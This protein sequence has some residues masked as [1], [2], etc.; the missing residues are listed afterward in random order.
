[1]RLQVLLKTTT[2]AARKPRSYQK[3]H[4]KYPSWGNCQQGVRQHIAFV[5]SHYQM[6]R[7]PWLQPRSLSWCASCDA[8]EFERATPMRSSTLPRVS[9]SLCEP[10]S[11]ATWQLELSSKRPRSVNRSLVVHQTRLA[12]HLKGSQHVLHSLVCTSKRRNGVRLSVSRLR[13][14]SLSPIR[15]TRGLRK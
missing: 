3:R 1:M 5:M 9:L 8:S 14:V 6:K 13:C 2:S 7:L 4:Q 10:S 12:H 11:H 15:G